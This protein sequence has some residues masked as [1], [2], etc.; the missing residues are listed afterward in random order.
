[1]NNNNEI[2]NKIQDSLSEWKEPNLNKLSDVSENMLKETSQIHQ[3]LYENYFN[4]PKQVHIANISQVH[5][6]FE[7]NRMKDWSEGPR[8]FYEH[9]IKSDIKI[10][11]GK[12]VSISNEVDIN[13]LN[14]GGDYRR[15]LNKLDT[16]DRLVSGKLQD[17]NS[18]LLL[19]M[20]ST[21]EKEKQSYF[22]EDRDLMLFQHKYES[23]YFK[24]NV[25]L[26]E[27]TLRPN[28]IEIISDS[29]VSKANIY[30]N[31]NPNL[32]QQAENL[33]IIE[34][35]LDNK[36]TYSWK[37]GTRNFFNNDI[38]KEIRQ[39]EG[40]S[41][42]LYKL[43]DN[44]AI[45]RNNMEKKH[46]FNL[47]NCK[48]EHKTELLKQ[49]D[50]EKKFFNYKVEKARMGIANTVANHDSLQ[51]AKNELMTSYESY[52]ALKEQRLNKQTPS[53]I[54]EEVKPIISKKSED[55]AKELSNR[56]INKENVINRIQSMRN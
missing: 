51:A 13:L 52:I 11:I 21:H 27:R 54:C 49:V 8:N 5:K 39:T 18:S 15:E 6:I 14:N 31:L 28:E 12:T 53:P 29:L 50:L 9:A 43:R 33:K 19:E 16:N 55:L 38:S 20:K 23:D 40:T 17:L 46:I 36:A 10:Q 35:D 32:K 25:S 7:E 45:S 47:Q 48:P 24:Y 22:G 3:D 37:E 26:E 1:M 4:E 41:N 44:V 34:S 56:L 42:K 2:F 30:N